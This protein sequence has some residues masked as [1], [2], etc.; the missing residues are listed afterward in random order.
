MPYHS[1][2]HILICTA[3]IPSIDYDVFIV[4]QCHLKDHLA[5]KWR[6]AMIYSYYMLVLFHQLM[7]FMGAGCKLMEDPGL[8]GLWA[9]V[10][11][12]NSL[13]KMM[14]SFLGHVYWPML[15]CIYLFYKQLRVP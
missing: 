12:M 10:C 7:S 14:E 4:L 5:E 1:H 3:F 15:H 2:P 13:P 9:T 11:D 6:K 8:D